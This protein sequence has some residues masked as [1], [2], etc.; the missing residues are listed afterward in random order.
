[1][2]MCFS[3]LEKSQSKGQA[4]KSGSSVLRGKGE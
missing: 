3:L 4:E 2:L 1:M